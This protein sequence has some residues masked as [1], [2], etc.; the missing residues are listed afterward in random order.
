ML[1]LVVAALEAMGLLT[2]MRPVLALQIV[3]QAVEV[4]TEVVA[5]Q[6]MVVRV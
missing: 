1:V 2:I 6:V 3:V 5:T 4:N